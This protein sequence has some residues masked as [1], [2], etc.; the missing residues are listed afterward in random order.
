[1]RRL[2][3]SIPPLVIL[4]LTPFL[5]GKDDWRR[6]GF[7]VPASQV[8][9]AAKRVISQHHELK[10]SDDERMILRFHVGTTAW[11]WGYNISMTVEATG[12]RTSEAWVAIEKSGGPVFSWGSGSKEVKKIWGWIHEELYRGTQGRDKAAKE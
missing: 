11:S 2:R 9:Q 7:T 12:E 10:A 5:F 3:L 1:M 4:L 6:E 8:Y